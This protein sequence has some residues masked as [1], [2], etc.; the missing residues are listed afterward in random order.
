MK[1]DTS[2]P[3]DWNKF[4]NDLGLIGLDK[5]L[6]QHCR[7][8]CWDFPIIILSLDPSQQPFL[9]ESTVERLRILLSAHYDF[10]N[11]DLR[12]FIQIEGKRFYTYE[13]FMKKENK[14][15]LDAIMSRVKMKDI[16]NG[17]Y[18]ACCPFHK[19]TT[20]SFTWDNNKQ[21]YHCFGCGVHGDG[22]TFVKEYDNHQ[23]IEDMLQG[24]R[25]REVT[26]ETEPVIKQEIARIILENKK[27]ID[28]VLSEIQQVDINNDNL[29]FL[30][31]IKQIQ[32]D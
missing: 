16:S 11:I 20:P 21:F 17:Q 32:N 14:K 15:H 5:L 18:L 23:L 4:I 28:S 24:R 13:A 1:L 3:K 8:D 9:S 19:E 25:Q 31:G 22:E 12:I 7:L 30:S 29:L 10:K 26:D 27:R 6:M 2:Q